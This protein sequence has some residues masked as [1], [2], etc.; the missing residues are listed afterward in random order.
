MSRNTRDVILDRLEELKDRLDRAEDRAAA[1]EHDLRWVLR[2]LRFARVQL[3]LPKQ[4]RI[5]ELQIRLE[6]W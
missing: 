6:A 1:C 3:P 2:E 4:L 5:E